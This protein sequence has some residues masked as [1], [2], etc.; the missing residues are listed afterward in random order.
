[1]SSGEVEGGFEP[2]S[3]SRVPTLDCLPGDGLRRHQLSQISG[4]GI[5]PPASYSKKGLFL[6]LTA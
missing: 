1:M 2:T 5:L 6:F 3:G 4:Q